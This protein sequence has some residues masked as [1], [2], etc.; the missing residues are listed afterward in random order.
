MLVNSFGFKSL[1]LVLFFGP[2]FLTCIEG[3]STGAGGIGGPD[4]AVDAFRTQVPQYLYDSK[5]AYKAGGRFMGALGANFMQYALIIGGIG[6][7]AAIIEDY[8]RTGEVHPEVALDFLTDSSFMKAALGIFAGATIFSFAALALPA[9]IP[10]FLQIVPGFF[11]AHLGLEVSQGTF[12][13]MN[14][15]KALFASAAASAAFVAMGSGVLAIGG[16]IL[17]SMAANRFYDE[18]FKK[19]A[20]YSAPPDPIPLKAWEPVLE[21]APESQSSGVK[22]SS[23]ETRLKDRLLFRQREDAARTQDR[24]EFLRLQ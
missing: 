23:E 10:A 14:M 8:R 1:L 7:S 4:G 9:G 24:E 12:E 19:E 16:G 18:F 17:A 6:A 13:D 20:I 21:L 2:F 3:A 15:V 5:S 22:T 11:G